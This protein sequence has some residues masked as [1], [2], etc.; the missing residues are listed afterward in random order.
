MTMVRKEIVDDVLSF[1]FARGATAVA[2]AEAAGVSERTARR[3]L[4][5]PEFRM[6]VRRRRA[7]LFEEAS[8]RTVGSSMRAA[9]V[10]VDILDHSDDEALRVR[11][12]LALLSQARTTVTVD[13][14][15]ERVEE[16]E[17]TVRALSPEA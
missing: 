17:S 14:L 1:E 5:E 9:E 13:M 4:D 2:A 3:R 16:L 12:A 11:V 10:L 8:A 15:N 7:A 6:L